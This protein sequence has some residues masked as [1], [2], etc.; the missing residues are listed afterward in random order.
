MK[1]SLEMYLEIKVLLKISI[2]SVM[3][4]TKKKEKKNNCLE[5]KEVEKLVG[6]WFR[7]T[8][9]G[10]IRKMLFVQSRCV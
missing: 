5:I 2:Y 10:R 7:Q 8:N 4:G 1:L 3:H 6:V 9:S